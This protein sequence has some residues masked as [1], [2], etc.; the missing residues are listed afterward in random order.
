MSLRT[1][2]II[3]SLRTTVFECTDVYESRV[4]YYRAKEFFFSIA[5]ESR[6]RILTLYHAGSNSVILQSF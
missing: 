6:Y 3:A 1:H 5:H 2:A 4:F